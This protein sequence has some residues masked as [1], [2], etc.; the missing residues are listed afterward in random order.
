MAKNRKLKLRIAAPLEPR[1]KLSNIGSSHPY[2]T[3]PLMVSGSPEITESSHPICELAST[4]VDV[5]DAFV[6]VSAPFVN[7]LASLLNKIGVL[8]SIFSSRRLPAFAR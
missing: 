8:L 3:P 4:Q 5:V 7:P 2:L 6:H 1:S